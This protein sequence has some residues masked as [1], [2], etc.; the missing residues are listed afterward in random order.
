M[1]AGLMEMFRLNPLIQTCRGY[2]KLLKDLIGRNLKIIQHT[3]DALLLSNQKISTKLAST[4]LCSNVSLSA[5]QNV[6]LHQNRED[7]HDSHSPC[8]AKALDEIL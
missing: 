4:L 1:D 6:Y 7:L 3:F 5:I 8:I 2:D